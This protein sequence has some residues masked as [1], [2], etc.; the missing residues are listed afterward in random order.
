MET[1]EKTK[2]VVINDCYGGFG[3]SLTAIE[4]LAN[5]KGHGELHHYL[6]EGFD[7]RIYR[8]VSAEEVDSNVNHFIFTYTLTKD[9]GDQFEE[10]EFHNLFDQYSYKREFDRHDVD[11][12]KVVETLGSKAASGK[13]SQ[14]KIVEIPEDVDYK[15][16]EYDGAE[17]VAETHRTWG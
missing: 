10:E 8:K 5:L 13:F 1:K 9:V 6:M 14:L 7:T 11:L 16:K 4:M 12:V 3:L 2:K 15:I 17:W